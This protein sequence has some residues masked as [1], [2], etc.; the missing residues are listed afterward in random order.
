M[1]ARIGS[2]SR[3]SSSCSR[4]AAGRGA[5][6]RIV[7]LILR[8]RFFLLISF[9]PAIERRSAEAASALAVPSHERDRLTCHQVDHNGSCWQMAYTPLNNAHKFSYTAHVRGSL[10]RTWTPIGNPSGPASMCGS[11]VFFRANAEPAP[12]PLMEVHFPNTSTPGTA[13]HSECLRG[14]TWPA[15]GAE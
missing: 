9:S 15:S 5:A 6:R 11:H 14:V 7:P 1:A 4:L 13:I 8:L 12:I 10:S 2:M 3:D